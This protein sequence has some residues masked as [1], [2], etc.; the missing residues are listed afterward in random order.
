MTLGEV[1]GNVRLIKANKSAGPGD[2]VPELLKYWSEKHRMI[3]MFQRAPNTGQNPKKWTKTCIKKGDRRKCEIY[4]G[5]SVISSMGRLYGKIVRAKL[6]QQLI[7]K[8]GED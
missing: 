7:G 2:I 4:R 3:H 1:K 8:I 5:I 6:E